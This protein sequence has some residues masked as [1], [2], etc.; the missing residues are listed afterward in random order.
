MYC[1]RVLS[2]VVQEVHCLLHNVYFGVLVCVPRF[3][4]ILY[5]NVYCY[6]RGVLIDIDQVS[7]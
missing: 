6:Y 2:A 5:N 4:Y 3:V 1:L 7:S